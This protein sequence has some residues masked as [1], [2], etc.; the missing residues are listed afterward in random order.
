M[1]SHFRSA[2]IRHSPSNCEEFM[3]LIKEI[4]SKVCIDQDKVELDSIL[5]VMESDHFKKIVEDLKSHL[6]LG[7]TPQIKKYAET[8]SVEHK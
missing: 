7:S 8:D 5:G 4:E 3:A 6:S 2:L 1:A